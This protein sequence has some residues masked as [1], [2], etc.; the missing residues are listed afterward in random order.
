MNNW[1]GRHLSYGLAKLHKIAL[2]KR[3]WLLVHKIKQYDKAFNALNENDNDESIQ[4]INFFIRD[5]Q[6]DYNFK[7]LINLIET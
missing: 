4:R 5:K 7:L 6:N 3:I 2:D 1:N